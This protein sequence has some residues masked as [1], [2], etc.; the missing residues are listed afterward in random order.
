MPDIC[1]IIANHLTWVTGIPGKEEREKWA[2]E[3][4]EGIMA[5]NFFKIDE[6]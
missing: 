4:Y 1:G 2:E 6:K 5:N 3:I